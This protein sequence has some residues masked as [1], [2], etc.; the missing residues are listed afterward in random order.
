[1]HFW[2]IHLTQKSLKLKPTASKNGSVYFYF[3]L[4]Q[5]KERVDKF[6]F[7]LHLP[8]LS[9]FLSQTQVYIFSVMLN[10]LVW[11]LVLSCKKEVVCR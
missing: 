4:L 9:F 5:E 8:F 11:S 6:S 10:V 1:M 3:F 2:R 7:F